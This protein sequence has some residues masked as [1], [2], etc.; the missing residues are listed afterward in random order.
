MK[1]LDGVNL[2]NIGPLTQFIV[3]GTI[4][5]AFLGS[6]AMLFTLVWHQ[7]D[8]PPGVKEILCLLIGVLA[9]EFGGMC[10]FWLGS[11]NASQVKT[12]IIG[13]STP[14]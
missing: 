14:P 6:I 2:T 4:A 10:A 3:S 11:T 8:V 5:F 13:R 12:E 9:R 7:V 1:F